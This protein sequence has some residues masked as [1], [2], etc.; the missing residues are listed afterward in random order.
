M[1]PKLKRVRTIAAAI[2]STPGTLESLDAAD[3]AFIVF[4]PIIQQK[5]EMEGRPQ[6]GGFG[7]N[8]AIPGARLGE[9]T[10][11]SE[12]HADSTGPLWAR[13]FLAACGLGLNPTGGSSTTTGGANYFQLDK[14]PPEAS[15]STQKSIS[16][17]VYEDGLLKRLH[18]CM[19]NV[20]FTFVSG[21]KVM[22]EFTFTGVW[23]APT[24]ATI[25]A[26]TYPTTSPLRFI[27]SSFL[28]GAWA[29]K[30][31]QLTLDLGNEVHVREDSTDATGYHCA[32]IATRLVKGTLNPESETVASKDVYG[33]WL[34]STEAALSF[35][36]SAGSDACAFSASEL[37]FLNPQEGERNGVQTDDIEFQLNADDLKL[38]FST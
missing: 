3:A 2:E 21:K 5:A 17:G 31:Q 30:I 23:N 16:I 35:S 18:G 12:L 8:A 7:Q 34:A 36:A 13:T 6:A 22:L 11:S 19:G 14:L 28:I 24:D 33:D 1:T 26:P 38:A 15:G 29:P 37:Q 27:S 9:V 4:D 25:L 10:F 20:K 32:V